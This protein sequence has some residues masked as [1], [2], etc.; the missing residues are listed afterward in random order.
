M[1][2]MATNSV[3]DPERESFLLQLLHFAGWRLEIRRGSSTRIRAARSGVELD[4]T[5]PSLSHAAGTLFARAM[6]SSS[7]SGRPEG[8]E[9]TR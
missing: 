4:V 3:G 7:A 9:W 5:G 2:G 6:R 8:A 1:R